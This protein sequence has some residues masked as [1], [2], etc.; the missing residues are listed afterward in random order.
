[1]TSAGV[2]VL[3]DTSALYALLD[4]DDDRHPEAAGI[5]ERLLGEVAGGQAAMCTHGGVV[6]ET[7]A[8]VQRRLGMAALRD[9][10]D[11]LLGPVAVTW[12]D[13][14]LFARAV[15]A[16]LAAGDRSVSLVDWLS[17]EL[18]RERG[19]HRAFAFDD[20]FERRGFL[21]ER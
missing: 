10:H 9:L 19:I 4:R 6:I 5:W 3:V 17:F 14:A 7:S 20:D 15:A 1:M 8:V 13:A 16:L 18:M 11:G 12:P 2:D 21:T